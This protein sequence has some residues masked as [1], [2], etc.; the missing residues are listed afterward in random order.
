MV[1]RAAAADA[2]EV[3]VAVRVIA[4]FTRLIEVD[5]ECARLSI[6]SHLLSGRGSMR[7]RSFGATKCGTESRQY[8]G[9][10]AAAASSGAR[11]VG[12]LRVMGRADGEEGL[13]WPGAVEEIGGVRSDESVRLVGGQW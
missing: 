4:R 11:V 6:G 5:W 13:L 10:A 3:F 1:V 9:A 8:G 12:V 2:V 7:W